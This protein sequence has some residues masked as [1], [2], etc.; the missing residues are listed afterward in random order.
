[1]DKKTLLM[2]SNFRKTNKN[3]QAF[4]ADDVLFHL[5]NL[6]HIYLHEQ[7]IYLGSVIADSANEYTQKI[8]G[9]V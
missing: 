7:I 1:M 6:T 2:L 5:G 8:L 9:K 3:Q 4:W